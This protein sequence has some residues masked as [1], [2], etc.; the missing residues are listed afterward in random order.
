M[1]HQ[2]LVF[3]LVGLAM[4]VATGCSLSPAA[5]DLGRI[6]NEP[7]QNIGADRN[8]VIV[9]PGV[10][11]SKLE[12]PGTHRPIWG[13]F[14]YGAADADTAEGA[15]LVA[16]PMA[17][18]APLR[19][20]RD[21]VVPT[22]VLDTLTLDIALIRGVELEAYAGILRTL[23]A[24]KY[25]DD[26]LQNQNEIDYAGVHYTCFQFA[27]DWRRDLSEQAARLHEHI[28]DAKSA[29]PEGGSDKVDIVAHSMGGL[30]LRY[31]LRYGPTPLPDDGS[32]PPLT[33]EGARHVESA[34]VIGT[35]SAGSVL[36]LEQLCHGVNFAALITPN[37]RAAVL[38]SMPGIYQL[39]PRPRHR[40]IALES[41]EPV[42]VL[43]PAVWERFGWGLADPRQD[44][45]LQQLLPQVTSAEERRAIALDHLRKIL[46]RTR[47]FFDAIDAPATPPAGTE[48]FLIAGDAT[49]T[50]DRI[51]VDPETG[52]VVTVGDAPGDGTVTRA[53]A[54]MDERVGHAYIPRLRSPIDWSIVQFL[55]S[56]HIGLTKDPLFNNFVL[57]TL[58]ERPRR[59]TMSEPLSMP[60]DRVRGA[61][62]R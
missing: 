51:S 40:L 4:V 27:Y 22:E 48:L 33:W 6:Y 42:D 17:Q 9:I 57:Y 34:I 37:Y 60:R 23:A 19:E 10:L 55:A 59:G 15:R 58:L 24:G 44:R 47:Q 41:G 11:G 2:W 43:D 7:A 8:P 62:I 20:L 36:A 50:P 53:S 61:V 12:E 49:P 1:R 29:Q 13:S 28:L 30:L 5:P 38:G 18:G 56:S 46:A 31:Y 39:L 45:V 26:Q 16:L 52:E 35:P 25:R 14:I 32:L 3:V 54:L 21:E